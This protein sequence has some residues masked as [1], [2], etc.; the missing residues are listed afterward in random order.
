MNLKPTTPTAR[1]VFEVLVR[2]HADHLLV[3]L[4]AIVRDKSTVDDIFQETMMVAW[5]RLS[6]FDRSRSF[7]AWVRGIGCRIAMDHAGRRRIAAMDPV[8]L[9]EVEAHSAAFDGDHSIAFQSRLATLD[10]CI[11]RLPEEY[12]QAVRLVYSAQLPLR[13]IASNLS[14]TE[15]AIKKRIQRARAMLGEC[16]R[17]KGVLA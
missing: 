15:E 2:D 7:G 9:Q 12:A 3:Y 5:R 14:M 17:H 8:V 16:L 13:T 4:R 1:E 10:D 11:E 6:D